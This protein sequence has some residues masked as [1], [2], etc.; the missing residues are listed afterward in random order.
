MYVIGPTF[1]YL[2]FIW[3]LMCYLEIKILPN[4][5]FSDAGRETEQ[6][7]Y[8][9]RKYNISLPFAKDSCTVLSLH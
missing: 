3:R 6:N 4:Y 5:W 2:T 8:M 9:T 1:L 7:T